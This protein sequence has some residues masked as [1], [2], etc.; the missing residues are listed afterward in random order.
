MAIPIPSNLPQIAGVDFRQNELVTPPSAPNLI[1]NINAIDPRVA[2]KV[3]LPVGD[4]ST[5]SSLMDSTQSLSDP[6]VEKAVILDIAALDPNQNSDS[7]RNTDNSTVSQSLSNMDS[8]GSVALGQLLSDLVIKDEVESKA[9]QVDSKSENQLKNENITVNWPGSASIE[10]SLQIGDLRTSLQSLYINLQN[11]GIFAAEQL[12]KL[13]LPA[14][15][16]A[17]TLNSDSKTTSDRVQSL[18]AELSGENSSVKDAIKLLLRGELVWQGQLLPNIY[19]KIHRSDA[20]DSNQKEAANLVKGSKLS[21]ELSFPNLGAVE[22]IG[23]QFD[24]I[25][26]IQIKSQGSSEGVLAEN[27]SDLQKKIHDEISISLSKSTS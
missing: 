8:L 4:L 16:Q 22:I 27:F 5:N 7:I 2:L 19:A 18:M 24:E 1:E 26:A 20:W 9:P 3:A 14:N 6:M 25:I 21:L 10:S 23:T 13:V 15:E 12:K 11:S 17:E